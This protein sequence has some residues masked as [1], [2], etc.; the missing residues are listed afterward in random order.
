[1]A[2]KSNIRERER[3]PQIILIGLATEGNSTRNVANINPFYEREDPSELSDQHEKHVS[4]TMTEFS[5]VRRSSGCPEL[6]KLSHP[7][8]GTHFTIG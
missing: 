1:M 5:I 3:Y 7:T 4:A 2:D 6:R 8:K